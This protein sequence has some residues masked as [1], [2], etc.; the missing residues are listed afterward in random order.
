MNRK[1]MSFTFEE[2]PDGN[3]E[4][5]MKAD[6]LNW[7]RPRIDRRFALCTH[8]NDAEVI[9]EA[10]NRSE[11]TGLLRDDPNKPRAEYYYKS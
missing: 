5:I 2:L 6:T 4:V 10:L 11:S 9:V 8:R 1:I 3:F 7:A